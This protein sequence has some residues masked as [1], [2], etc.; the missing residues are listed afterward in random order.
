MH[1]QGW[2]LATYFV[3]V[4]LDAA[5]DLGL[6]KCA[7]DVLHLMHCFHPIWQKEVAPLVVLPVF[8]LIE[9]LV[10]EPQAV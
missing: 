3:T 2:W 6:A 1:H 10:V 4:L 9:L 8:Y 5:L 7:A